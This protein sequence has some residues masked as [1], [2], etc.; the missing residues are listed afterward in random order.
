VWDQAHDGGTTPLSSHS[1]SG[2]DRDTTWWSGDKV[3]VLDLKDS[4]S[5]DALDKLATLQAKAKVNGEVSGDVIEVE[6]V[7]AAK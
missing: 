2:E 7:D 4:S 1:H 3:C 6:S 5:A